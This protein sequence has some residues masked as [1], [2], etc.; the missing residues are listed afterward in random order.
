MKKKTRKHLSQVLPLI[1]QLSRTISNTFKRIAQDEKLALTYEQAAVLNALFDSN[2]L[3]QQQLADALVKDKT[4]L[5]R[6]LDILERKRLI[7][8]KSSQSDKRIKFVFTTAEAAR[9]QDAI[10]NIMDAT[11]DTLFDHLTAAQAK[12]MKQLIKQLPPE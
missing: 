12:A 5:S 1:D 9:L 3:S 10:A 6:Q 8:R 4:S 7:E 11:L 2:G